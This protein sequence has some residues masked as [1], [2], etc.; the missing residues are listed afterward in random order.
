[1]AESLAAIAAEHLRIWNS[2]PGP[3]RTSAVAGIYASDAVVAESNATYRG[4]SGVEQAIDGLHAAL[5]GM[6]LELTSPIQTAQELSTYTWT[7]GP[8][9]Q[10]AVVTG[11]DALSIKEGAITAV[12]VFID[13]PQE[14]A[15]T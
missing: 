8:Q 13:A 2:Q 4:R 1:M 5:P 7:L 12:Y 11:R 10:P 9:G 6:Q 3:E 14:P 15:V